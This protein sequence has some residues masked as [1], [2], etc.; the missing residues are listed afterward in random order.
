MEY[1]IIST[2]KVK[3]TITFKNPVD[4]YKYLKRYAKSKQEQFIVITLNGA[5]EVIKIHIVTIGLVNKTIVHPREVFY[6][7]IQDNASAFVVAH[8]HP[9]G[10]L[11][12]SPED[13][14]ITERLIKAS[15]IMG[16]YFLDHLIINKEWYF[17]YRQESNL[18]NLTE[19]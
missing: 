3:K 19:K 14:E 10:K 18:F 16:I 13:D 6:R 17:S 12:P 4:I 8:N 7:A 9:S 1:E 2:R 15:E 11:T 5:H